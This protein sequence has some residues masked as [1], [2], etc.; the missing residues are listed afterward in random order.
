MAHEFGT[1]TFG[2][3]P[4]SVI[5]NAANGKDFTMTIRPRSER[6]AVDRAFRRAKLRL[7]DWDG[8]NARIDPRELYRFLQALMYTGEE[9]ESLRS[10]ML[11]VLG[12]E[13]I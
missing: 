5:V 12:I 10:G 2:T 11:E 7:S 4:K 1:F 9:G 3:T 6:E 8:E 13:E